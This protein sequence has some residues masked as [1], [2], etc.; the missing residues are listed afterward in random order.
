[1]QTYFLS[2]QII[3]SFPFH[4]FP[5][6]GL[7]KTIP[8]L[9]IHPLPWEMTS[10]IL[11]TR[12]MRHHSGPLFA[13]QRYVLSATSPSAL[14]E[15]SAALSPDI[16]KILWLIFHSTLRPQCPFF[17]ELEIF[18]SVGRWLKVI[19]ISVFCSASEALCS[20]STPAAGL[21]IETWLS[22]LRKGNKEKSLFPG[23]G[24]SGST[25]IKRT[26]SL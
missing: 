8:V 10:F 11:I 26:S 20:D 15:D 1:M 17:A 3:N 19:A 22:F 5:L 13:G 23:N 12:I 2:F 21:S 14:S 7:Q 4:W 25:I 6:V 16:S 9:T 18:P 24:T